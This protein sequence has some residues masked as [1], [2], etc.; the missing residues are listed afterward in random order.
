MEGIHLGEPIS[1]NPTNTNLALCYCRCKP[2]SEPKRRTENNTEEAVEES[3]WVRF[4]DHWLVLEKLEA[5]LLKLLSKIR[6]RNHADAPTSACNTIAD[7][8]PLW[9]DLE[10]SVD[11]TPQR[12]EEDTSRHGVTFF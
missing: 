10:R 5:K 4:T 1:I 9:W 7:S 3:T 11:Q 2:A 12:S 8:S 6:R